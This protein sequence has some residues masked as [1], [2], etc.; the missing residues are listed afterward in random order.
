MC[1]LANTATLEPGA[2]SWREMG[3]LPPAPPAPMSISYMILA[4][5][6]SNAGSAKT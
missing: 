5:M 3:L 6:L 1:A 2:L 4:L